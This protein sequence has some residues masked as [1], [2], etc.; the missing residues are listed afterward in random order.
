MAIRERDAFKVEE[1]CGGFIEKNDFRRKMFTRKVERKS[2]NDEFATVSIK[3]MDVLGPPGTLCGAFMAR[4][5]D[6]ARQSMAPH[7][8]VP[9][10]P[11]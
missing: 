9:R 11:I 7:G 5:Y 1:F 2:K 8:S 3:S 6:G 10:T 4:S